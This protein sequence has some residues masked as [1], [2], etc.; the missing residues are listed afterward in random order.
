MKKAIFASLVLVTVAWGLKIEN[1]GGVSAT[2]I[3]VT[4]DAQLDNINGDT[5]DNLY[6]PISSA[7]FLTP[8]GQGWGRFGILSIG[9]WGGGFIKH[10]SFGQFYNASI[11]YGIGNLEIGLCFEPF[12]WLFIKPAIEFGGSFALIELNDAIN[13]TT[14]NIYRSTLWQANAGASLTLQG[15][16]PFK[17]D[18]FLGIFVTGGYL[19]PVYPSPLFT[20]DPTGIYGP[21]L[22]AGINLGKKTERVKGNLDEENQVDLEGK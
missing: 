11:G 22:T 7:L 10:N 6:M 3:L 9:A 12:K 1:W 4:L 20:L 21:Y 14:L 17:E 2:G 13:D 8:T 15:N 16:I 19:F 18:R 5:S